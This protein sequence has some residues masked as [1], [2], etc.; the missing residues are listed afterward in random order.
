MG[1][2]PEN[3]D[4]EI[5]KIWFAGQDL[6][7]VSPEEAKKIFFDAYHRIEKTLVERWD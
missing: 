6:S 1:K 4:Y 3:V 2:I 5:T 7:N